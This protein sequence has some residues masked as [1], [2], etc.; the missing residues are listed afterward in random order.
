MMVP[1]EIDTIIICNHKG[2]YERESKWGAFTRS[3]VEVR[4][5]NTGKIVALTSGSDRNIIRNIFWKIQNN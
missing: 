5:T 2:M 1:V 3:F 4:Y